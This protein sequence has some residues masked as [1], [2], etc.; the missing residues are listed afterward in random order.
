MMPLSL[1]RLS[2]RLI[3]RKNNSL[4]EKRQRDD[5]TQS[6]FNQPA[7]PSHGCIDG[8]FLRHG[9]RAPRPSVAAIHGLVYPRRSRDSRPIGNHA[10][11][12]KT[13][14]QDLRRFV[15]VSLV[16][17][18]LSAAGGVRRLVCGYVC[19]LLVA[20]A[21]TCQ[22]LVARFPPDSPFTVAY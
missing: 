2:R 15:A 20:P 4:T 8:R 1:L 11:Y 14:D 9:T 3:A 10:Y 17:L 12:S 16:A 21:E 6:Q 18:G 19:I 7:D 22:G 5:P 13:M